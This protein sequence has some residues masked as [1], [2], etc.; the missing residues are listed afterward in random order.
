MRL[1]I[2]ALI[3]LL[4]L[5]CIHCQSAGMCGGETPKCS[6]YDTALYGTSVAYDGASLRCDNAGCKWTI[7]KCAGLAASCSTYHN[8]SPLCNNAGCDWSASTRECSGVPSDCTTFTNSDNCGNAVRCSWTS[9]LCSGDSPKA[10][11]EHS[12]EAACDLTGTCKWARINTTTTN[13]TTQACLPEEQNWQCCSEE[14]PCFYPLTGDC[15]TDE[16]CG[17]EL[18]C[19]AQNCGAGDPTGYMDCCDYKRCVSDDD[20]STYNMYCTL[21]GCGANSSESCCR[22]QKGRTHLRGPESEMSDEQRW[23]RPLGDEDDDEDEDERAIAS[24]KARPGIC[25][26]RKT[27]SEA[28]MC[29]SKDHQCGH[30]EG[31][32]DSNDDCQEGH[33]C[34]NSNCKKLVANLPSRSATMDCCE[35][36]GSATTTSPDPRPDT[37]TSIRPLGPSFEPTTTTTIREYKEKLR[38]FTTTIKEY[39]PSASP[40]RPPNPTQPSPA[41]G[42]TVTPYEPAENP[43]TTTSV[44]PYVPDGQPTEEP[45]STPD[46]TTIS[47]Y[48]PDD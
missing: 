1:F 37:T 48:V 24:N 27:A 5:Q 12:S 41:Y 43:T 31:D 35:R 13:P 10:C 21:N 26:P 30:G 33:F 29:C 2:R 16:A 39:E 45:S 17:P 3:G 42:T 28:W 19:G 46:G 23:F 4:A 14:S 25:S 15:E 44:T 7:G 9:G 36:R 22:R 20:C 18:F 11:E 40:T 47:P 32:C 6:R 38:E 8:H 34:G